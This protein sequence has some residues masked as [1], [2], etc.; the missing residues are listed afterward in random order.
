MYDALPLGRSTRFWQGEGARYAKD[1]PDRLK[2]YFESELT[3]LRDSPEVRNVTEIGYTFSYDQGTK[4]LVMLDAQGNY[5]QHYTIPQGRTSTQRQ[6]LGSRVQGFLNTVPGY[7]Q[8]TQPTIT[9]TMGGPIVSRPGDRIELG[10]NSMRRMTEQLETLRVHKN[11]LPEY[12]QGNYF[13][14]IRGR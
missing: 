8:Q 5:A 4:T 2:N 14:M 10:V 13:S 9:A 1:N 6:A 7:G 12:N 3:S 11:L